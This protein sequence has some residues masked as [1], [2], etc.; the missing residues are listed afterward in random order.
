MAL[1]SSWSTPHM[2]SWNPY[3]WAET[4]GSDSSVVHQCWPKDVH[5][6]HGTERRTCVCVCD[7]STVVCPNYC[8][9]LYWTKRTVLYRRG[10]RINWR[11]RSEVPIYGD[12]NRITG[13]GGREA[14]CHARELIKFAAKGDRRERVMQASCSAL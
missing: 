2:D 5:K 1:L 10:G 3:R 12:A 9:V 13:G 7:R 8:T 11:L 6:D 14:L 4:K